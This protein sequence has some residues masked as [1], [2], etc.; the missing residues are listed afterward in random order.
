[1]TVCY[2]FYDGRHPLMEE[3]L[4]WKTTFDIRRPSMEKII[5]ILQPLVKD[6]LQLKTTFDGEHSL[7]KQPQ[8][9]QKKG[10][11]LSF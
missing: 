9:E 11:K 5:K 3:N 10:R 7:A 6:D 1:M 4:Q 8:K 2:C